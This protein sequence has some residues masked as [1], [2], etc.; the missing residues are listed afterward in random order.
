MSINIAYIIAIIASLIA[1]AERI[2]ISIITEKDKMTNTRLILENK[3]EFFRKF[4][5]PFILYVIATS[6]ILL[7]IS[8]V[9]NEVNIQLSI[10]NEWV[11]LILGM[12]AMIIGVI[13]LYLS[14]YNVDQAQESQETTRK[15][16]DKAN[17]SFRELL[18]ETENRISNKIDDL[19]QKYTQENWRVTE[20]F[21]KTKGDTAGW[22]PFKLD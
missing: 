17:D 20:K 21:E 12:V 14:F 3:V 13:S 19:E 1:I 22:T 11:S 2:Y 7:F 10:V 15:L 5:S 16:L 6:I 9:K 18:K 8:S 4:W